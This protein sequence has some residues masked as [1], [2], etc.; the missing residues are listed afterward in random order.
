MTQPS[1]QKNKERVGVEE[2]RWK[3]SI[4]NLQKGQEDNAFFVRWKEKN[5]AKYPQQPKQNE[6]HEQMSKKAQSWTK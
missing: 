5:A 6:K 3:P 1:R 2:Q 4:K